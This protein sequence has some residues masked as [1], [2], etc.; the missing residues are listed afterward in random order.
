MGK[1]T[2]RAFWG[3]RR[4]ERAS[5]REQSVMGVRQP[6]QKFPFPPGWSAPPRDDALGCH[7]AVTRW[8]GPALLQRPQPAPGASPRSAWAAGEL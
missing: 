2:A 5:M 8:R 4:G 3:P 1:G 7:R 6:L